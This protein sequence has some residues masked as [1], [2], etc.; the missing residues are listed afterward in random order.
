MFITKYNYFI[1]HNTNINVYFCLELSQVEIIQS[2]KELACVKKHTNLIYGL[3][4]SPDNKYF[5]T[6]SRD[7]SIIISDI[8]NL[9]DIKKKTFN[10]DV[11]QVKYSPDQKYVA[12]CFKDGKVRLFESKTLN[13]VQCV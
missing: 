7:K 9:A 11:Y 12:G 5:V 3:S 1:I 13:E 10:S 2:L 6:G 8:E 4:I